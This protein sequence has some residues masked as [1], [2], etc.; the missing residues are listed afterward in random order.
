MTTYALGVTLTYD[1]RAIHFHL[2]MSR[3]L[4]NAADVVDAW[5]RNRCPPPFITK[6]G[7]TLYHSWPDD[8][9]YFLF[10]E[11]FIERCYTGSGFYQPKPKDVI[12]DLGANI[13]VFA[14][15]VASM[16]RDVEISCFEPS[17]QTCERL[18]H[19]VTANGLSDRISVFPLGLWKDHSEGRL[20][21]IGSS[22]RK[23]FFASPPENCEGAAEIVSCTTLPTALAM[24]GQ[25]KIDLLKIDTEGAELEILKYTDDR[26]WA[27]IERLT[28]E[29]HEELRPGSK[30]EILDLLAEKGYATVHVRCLPSQNAK[31]IGIIQASRV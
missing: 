25:K 3:F 9:I 6:S 11:I 5:Y 27:R 19:N 2:L 14:L 7:I 24:L 8:P 20:L 15:Y 21:G 28:L 18:F 16:V 13:G 22:A 23:S 29:Y 30:I 17:K 12:V 10:N 26:T 4:L 1:M 31:A